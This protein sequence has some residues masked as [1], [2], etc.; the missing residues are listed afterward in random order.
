LGWWI[1]D[2]DDGQKV[3]YMGGETR[4]HMAYLG[5]NKLESAGVIVLLNYNSDDNSQLIMGQEILKSINKY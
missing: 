2:L 4:G 1:L 5:F 3:I